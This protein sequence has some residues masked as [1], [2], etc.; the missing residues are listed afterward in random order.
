MLPQDH[1]D[2]LAKLIGTMEKVEKD[3]NRKYDLLQASTQNNDM[4]KR[5]LNDMEE[6]NSLRYD[7]QMMT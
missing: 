2:K 3:G 6:S 5:L 4:K 1:W 7:F